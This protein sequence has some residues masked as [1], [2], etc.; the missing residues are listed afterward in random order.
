MSTPLQWNII[1][2]M[3]YLFA[4]E[5]NENSI[6]YVV[7]LSDK[8]LLLFVEMSHMPS[9]LQ[10]ASVFKKKEEKSTTHLSIIQFY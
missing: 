2:K 10:L 9:Q 5:F 7:T 3:N 8:Q 6:V 1:N 4:N